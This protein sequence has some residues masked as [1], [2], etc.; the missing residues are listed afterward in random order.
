MNI[1]EKRPLGLILCVILG[2]FSLF[3]F[4]SPLMRAICI[5]F[6]I[7]F[8]IFAF[9]IKRFDTLIKIVSIG[10]LSSFL[11]SFL[12]FDVCF[13]PKELYGEST[14]FTAKVLDVDKKSDNLQSIK[15]K[16]R[17]VDSKKK[18]LKLNINVYGKYDEIK[19]GSIITFTAEPEELEKGEDFNFKNY[20]TSRGIS[21]TADI[22]YFEIEGVGREPIG[23]KCKLIREWISQR[24]ESLS[25]KRAGSMLSALL[26]GERDRL[27][28]QLN[29]DFLRTGITHILALSGT[30]VVLLA[31]AVN[32]FLA[33]FHVDKKYRLIA[34]SVFTFLFMALTGFPLSV[35]RAGI[36]LI[37]S[38]ILFLI[39]GCRDSITSLMMAS[40]L[41]ILVTPYAAFDV[42]LW[43][44]ILATGGILVA[45]EILN[46]NYSYEEGGKRF[47]RY[48]WLSFLYSLFAISATVILST[49]CFTGTSV[50]SALATFVFSILT[51]FYVYLGI[52]VLFVGRIIPLGKLL[53]LFEELIS[54][55]VGN[56]SDLSFAYSSSEF[57]IVQTLFIIL[58]I[59]F[60]VFAFAPIKRKALYLTYLSVLFVFANA[61]PIG[62]TKQIKSRDM[63]ACVHDGYDKILIR[64]NEEV[65]LIDISNSSK[66]TAYANNYLLV[67]ERIVELECYVVTNYY[68]ALPNSLNKVLSS[69]LVKEVKLPKALNDEQHEIALK[70][71]GIIEEYR[72]ELSFYE[73]TLPTRVLDFEMMIPFRSYNMSAVLLKNGNELYS[74]LSKG[75]LQYVKDSHQLL[76]VSDYMIF[77]GYGKAYTRPITIDS[78]DK[79]LK[80]VVSFDTEIDFDVSR[81]TWQPPKLYFTESKFYFY[82]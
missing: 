77:G 54:D 6:S 18:S 82:K 35:C 47:F 62:L 66:S 48:V 26:L 36:M 4:L 58:G 78:F 8:I 52:I 44:S 40:A 73:D 43:L 11:V 72:T 31:A 33:L 2:G 29:L 61:L 74:Y 63:L 28:G 1:F 81:T 38:T 75:L 13:Y 68:D 32:K 17:T 76:Q 10:L 45:V 20:Y 5:A 12:Y 80:T 14:E 19:P 55:L 7:S 64:K 69:N 79:R 59:S 23:Y 56:L 30:H 71:F 70:C 3:S 42:G 41:I 51:E 9:V 67:E 25:N 57:P 60:A 39:T 24:A 21:A 34:G 49:L 53:I 15:V 37:L 50:V 46:E 16:T 27:S 22:S 65:A